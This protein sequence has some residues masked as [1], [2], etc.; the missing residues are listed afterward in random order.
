MEKVLKRFLG[1]LKKKTAA[2]AAA[3][4]KQDLRQKMLSHARLNFS[5]QN[6]FF[7]SILTQNWPLEEFRLALA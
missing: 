1:R 5:T 6:S 4:E 2:A 3:N 7:L